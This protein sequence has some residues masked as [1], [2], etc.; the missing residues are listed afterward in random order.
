M[1]LFRYIFR[2]LPVIIGW[3]ISLFPS[4]IWV[5]LLTLSAYMNMASPTDWH[6]VQLHL[7]QTGPHKDKHTPQTHVNAHLH[8]QSSWIIQTHSAT[9]MIATFQLTMNKITARH[10]RMVSKWIPS[11]F[12]LPQ[13]GQAVCPLALSLWR[14]KEESISH[15]ESGKSMT[16]RWICVKCNMSSVSVNTVSAWLTGDWQ[17]TDRG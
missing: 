15:M 9:D 11:N 4:F 1:W 13:L 3:K 7:K 2:T 6:T 17:V 16:V 8:T 12:N 10:L 5:A 14:G